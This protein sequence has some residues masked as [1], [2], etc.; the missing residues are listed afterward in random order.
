M[1]LAGKAA[2]FAVIRDHSDQTSG[3]LTLEVKKGA[4]AKLLHRKSHRDSGQTVTN[5]LQVNGP[6]NGNQPSALTRIQRPLRLTPIA[7]SLR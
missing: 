4:L 7:E 2:T 3:Q 1:M 5:D 6:A